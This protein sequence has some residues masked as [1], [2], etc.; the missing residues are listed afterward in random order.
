L[1]RT[2]SQMQLALNMTFKKLPPPQYGWPLVSYP[3]SNLEDHRAI[4]VKNACKASRQREQEKGVRGSLDEA[5]T[6][7]LANS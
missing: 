3:V 1:G 4:R 5:E 2:Y 7:T 6:I